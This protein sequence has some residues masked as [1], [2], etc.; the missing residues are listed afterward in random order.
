MLER[1][2]L[3]ASFN[4]EWTE[5]TRAEWIRAERVAGFRP[6]MSSWEPNYNDT[7][8]T[9]GFSGG[10]VSGTYTTDGKTPTW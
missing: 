10:N 2:F 4:K 9:G 3:K 7:L 5:V 1:F 8:A 6:K